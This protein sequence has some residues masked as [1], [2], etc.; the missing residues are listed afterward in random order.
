MTGAPYYL[1]QKRN[2]QVVVTLTPTAL[3]ISLYFFTVKSAVQYTYFL[4]DS[5]YLKGREF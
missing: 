5:S 1:Q 4:N 2:K 3:F